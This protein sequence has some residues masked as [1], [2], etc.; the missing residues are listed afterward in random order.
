MV[1]QEILK[2][3]QEAVSVWQQSVEISEASFTF[4]VMGSAGRKE[5]L[6]GSDQD[7]G[8]IF[9]DDEEKYQAS[10]VALGR[11]ISQ[12]LVDKGYPLCVGHVMSSNPTW[13]RSLTGWRIQL[14][15]WLDADEWTTL[16]GVLIFMDG[17][18]LVGDPEHL[19]HLKQRVWTR[20][21]E[22]PRLLYRLWENTAW[23]KKGVGVFG[24]FLAEEKGEHAGSLNL[25]ETCVFPFVNAVRLLAIKEGIMETST[26]GRLTL[27]VELPQYDWL[28]PYIPWYEKILN[29]RAQQA[30]TAHRDF[31]PL[32][33]LGRAE[34]HELKQMVYKARELYGQT[35]RWLKRG[36]AR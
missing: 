3:V 7:H 18:P 20:C 9:Q 33:Q 30:K 2:A 4:F 23:I 1:D 15:S 29:L 17:W 22:E 11:Q 12:R 21:A 13:C 36:L 31:L 14:D 19:H 25:K 26:M 5:Y 6:P 24:Q 27:L 35:G 28:S 8:L 34:K 32:G 10:F 16:R